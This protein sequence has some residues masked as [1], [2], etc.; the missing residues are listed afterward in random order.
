MIRDT[1]RQV[2]TLR[3]LP[4]IHSTL[5]A[6]LCMIR[7]AFSKRHHLSVR[8]QHCLTTGC[9]KLQYKSPVC[10]QST[11]MSTGSVSDEQRWAFSDG[12]QYSRVSEPVTSVSKVVGK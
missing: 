12:H 10:A 1:K 3:T 9:F 7:Q 8:I 5:C 2:H 11:S 6:R 4:S